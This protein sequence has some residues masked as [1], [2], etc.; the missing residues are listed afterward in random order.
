MK[1]LAAIPCFNE[2]IPVAYVVLLA[3]EHVDEVLVVDDGSS[4]GTAEV[5]RA[6]G[7]QVIRH[8]KNKGKGAA[9]KAALKYAAGNGFDAL[10]LLDGDGQHD[11]A[12][13]P[14][15]LEPIQTVHARHW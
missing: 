13:I 9:V 10:V 2:R 15:L 12:Q 3:R 7:A 1:T 4:D 5:A 11:P 6:A 8:E 14:Q